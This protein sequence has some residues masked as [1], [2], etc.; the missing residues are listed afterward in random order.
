MTDDRVRTRIPAQFKADGLSGRG[1]VRNVS[2][3]GLFVGTLAIPEE[4][5]AVELTLCAPGKVD[6]EVKGLV[7][8]TAPAGRANPC[9]FGL[10]V[11]D[12]D[13]GYR[14]LVASIR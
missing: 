3:G 7:W 10:R 13:E 2:N 9:G 5:S 1:E 8:W 14:T 4:G 11:L 12:E 6:V